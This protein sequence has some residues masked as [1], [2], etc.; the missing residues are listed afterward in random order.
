M[1]PWPFRESTLKGDPADS[2]VATSALKYGCRLAAVD[3][4]LIAIVVVTSF[5]IQIQDS[6]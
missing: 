6:A 5:R 1:R 4:G 2:L 3:S